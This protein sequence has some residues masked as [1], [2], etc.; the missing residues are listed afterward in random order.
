M[1]LVSLELIETDR[2]RSLK[3]QKSLKRPTTGIFLPFR[4]N[5]NSLRKCSKKAF[6]KCCIVRNKIKAKAR[7]DK[8]SK[9]ASLKVLVGKRKLNAWKAV[10]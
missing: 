3:L 10:G 9:A 1:I 2:S 6:E 8:L 5:Q 4:R 7:Q